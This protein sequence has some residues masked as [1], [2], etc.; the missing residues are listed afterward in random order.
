M[1]TRSGTY[2]SMTLPTPPSLP[3]NDLIL[4][5]FHAQVRARTNEV[6]LTQPLG[7]DRVV[8]YTW[9]DVSREARR[10][11]AYLKGLN[12][13]AGSRIG[14]V[15]KNCAHFIIADLGIW[16]AG[17]VTVAAFPTLGADALMTIFTHAEV[18][19]VLI[20]KLDSMDGVNGGI[21]AGVPTVAMPLAPQACTAPRW[22]DKV[23]GVEPLP[24]EPVRPA[25]DLAILIYTSGSTGVPKGV[26]HSFATMSAGAW[27]F[28]KAFHSEGA[29]RMLSYLPLAHVFERTVVESCCFLAGFRVYFAESLDTFVQDLKRARPTLFVSV[30]RLWLK[31]QQGVLKKMPQKKLS[32]LLGIPLLGGVV[33]R[34]VLAGLGLEHVRIAGSGSAPI[35]P[36]LIQWYRNLGLELLEGYAMSENFSCSHF[37]VPGSGRVGYVGQPCAGVTCRISAEGEIQVKSPGTMLGYYKEPALTEEAFTADGYLRTGDRGEVDDKNR[38]RITGRTKELFKTAKGKYVAPVPIENIINADNHVELSCVAGSGQ[39][40]AF[41][42]VQISEAI[43]PEVVDPNGR[44]R[45]KQ[46]LEA[47]VNRVNSQVESYEQLEFVVVTPTR[48]SIENGFLTPTMKIKRSLIEEACAPHLE[49][50]FKAGQR[51]I[52]P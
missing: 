34:K 26:M 47:L 32:M 38:L 36:E 43:L 24:G 27:P 20:G 50:W 12:L 21:P 10:F 19:L 42:V 18:S 40:G 14:M 22:E 28:V 11:A 16:M 29:D 30:P 41:A 48:W 23:K 46:A 17:H 2:G 45:V 39:A 3:D 9:S 44:E 35:P 49:T 33:G 15:S 52:W 8:D 5:R 37:S 4:Q 25:G 7:G 1:R 13:P 6:M 51:V 31:F